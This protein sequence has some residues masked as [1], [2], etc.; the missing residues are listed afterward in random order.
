MS[1]PKD[2]NSTL[3]LFRK[4]EI[5]YGAKN[6]QLE[7]SNPGFKPATFQSQF[8]CSNSGVAW[9]PLSFKIFFS[10]IR[11][12]HFLNFDFKGNLHDNK[13]LEKLEGYNYVSG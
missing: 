4:M 10:D 13:K 12:N 8:L 2:R 9:S 5:V 7:P 6:F 1:F 11:L 3:C